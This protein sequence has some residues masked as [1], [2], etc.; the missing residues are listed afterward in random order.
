MI[1]NIFKSILL[2]DPPT[3]L[4]VIFDFTFIC[5]SWGFLFW[6][7]Q[8][9]IYSTLYCFSGIFVVTSLFAGVYKSTYRYFNIVDLLKILL[10]IL[11]SFSISFLL[12]MPDIGESLMLNYLFTSFSILIIPRLF[13]KIA[14]SE[15][16]ENKK[17]L[18]LILGAG[19]N[20]IY[21]KRAYQNNLDFKIGG[22][23]DDDKSKVGKIID[24]ISVYKSSDKSLKKLKEKGFTHVIF[25]TDN[26]TL[27]RKNY[28]LKKLTELG[29]IVFR[30]PSK[31]EI[32]NQKIG[33]NK[34]LEFS[35]DELLS[36]DEISIENQKFSKF[37]CGKN[38][39]VTGG[40]GSIGS[41]IIN[42]LK[43]FKNITIYGIDNSEFNL[44]R[45]IG[46]FKNYQN[47]QFS[48]IDITNKHSISN[49]FK[50]NKIDIVFNAA[51]YKHVPIFEDNPFDGFRNN[52]LGCKYLIDLSIEH[53]V[54]KFILV[55]SDKAVNPTNLMG[56]S[57]RLCE[58]LVSSIDSK[59][60]KTKFLSTRFGNVLDSSGSVVPTFKSQIQ[61]G[62]PI[63]ITDFKIERYFMTIPEA[64]KL[65][66]EA[67]R[68]GDNGQIFVFDMGNPVKIYDL[69]KKMLLLSGL[70]ENDIEIKEIGLRKGEKLFEELFLE[71]E[72]ERISNENSNL[73]IGRKIKTAE[74]QIN[75]IGSLLEI[76]KNS[77]I[78]KFS[79]FDI[80][81]V[82]PEYQKIL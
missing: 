55:S 26:F 29:F 72:V 28:L 47:I 42:Q 53:E 80:K 9:E 36:R 38:I 23:L 54:E 18:A 4:K 33:K 7:F 27:K 20:G 78:D 70:S 43:K 61:N 16:I 51:A 15:K 73:F 66:L 1:K 65:V 8:N 63:T 64:S 60:S 13:L 2:N 59:K 41:E 31:N 58:T 14:Y 67:T 82:V 35:V 44:F 69:A 37:I 68:I 52:V 76:L 3:Y 45:A 81:E 34:V 75:R 62:G 24:G 57:K 77:D 6:F 30:L 12:I 11:F 79:K 25:S 39:L 22:F 50:N 5:T 46:K 40:A 10:I 71:T 19:E 74:H 17:G 56:A 32:I 49:F 21:F 48:L